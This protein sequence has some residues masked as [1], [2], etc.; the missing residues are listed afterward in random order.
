MGMTTLSPELLARIETDVRNALAEDVGKGDL[1]AALVPAG[2]RAEAT[3][4]SREPG[5]VCGQ[6]WFDEVFRALADEISVDWQ[7]EESGEVDAGELVCTLSGPARPLLTGERTAMNFLQTLSATAT[8]ANAFTRAVA[9]SGATILDTRKTIPGLRNA[10]KYAVRV[11]GA[12]NH[13]M[14]LYDAILIKENHIISAGSIA[15]AVAEARRLSP[16]VLVEVE[17]ENHDELREALAAGADQVLLDNFGNS[18]LA[19]AVAIRNE[20]NQGVKLEA[21]GG[22]NLDT[23]GRIAATGVDYISVG[24][25]TKDIRA[26][27]LSLRFELD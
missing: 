24:A 17:V 1:T 22:V 23:V 11:G 20:L 21:S 3:L 27:D 13:R 26:L 10:Q 5:I 7:V 4:I 15:A 14:G 6:P 16:A 9:G 12:R 19:E 25:L 8:L 2:Q 18:A